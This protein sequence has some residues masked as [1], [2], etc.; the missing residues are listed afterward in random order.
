[1]RAIIRLRLVDHPWLICVFSR[2]RPVE[3]SLTFVDGQSIHEAFSQIS[4]ASLRSICLRHFPIVRAKARSELYVLVAQAP[5]SIQ[6]LIRQLTLEALQESGQRYSSRTKARPSDCGPGLG[7]TPFS[8]TP[9][10]SLDGREPHE[11]FMRAPS[12]ETI[13]GAIEEFIDRT[14]N[15][16]LA[17]GVCAVC[18]CETN[19]R[20][21]SVQRLN[22][23]PNGHRLRPT[24]AHPH[25]TLFDE[26]LL[27]LSGITSDT[28]ANVC[29]ECTRALALDKIPTFALA[30]GMWIGDIPHEL[31]YL[32]LPERLLI[33]K[34]FPAAYIIKLYPKKKGA[35]HW[36]KRQMYSG[37]KGNVSTYQLDQNQISSM[38]DGS[39]MP[40]RTEV[41]AATIGITFVGPKNL[42]DRGLPDLFK[43]RRLRVQRALEWLKANNPLFANITISASRLA[44]LP[45]DG[46]PYELQATTKFSSDT[47]TL[48]AEQDGYVPSQDANEDVE[49]GEH[50][51]SSQFSFDVPWD[52][53][54]TVSD[55]SESEGDCI[56]YF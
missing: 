32:T 9:H 45:E 27:H 25:H 10:S 50:S 4:A 33:A 16:A 56:F 23:I 18:A 3:D 17:V 14:N 43:V 38:V 13:D 34:Y 54:S 24:E 52:S 42:P 15:L 2:K 28:S 5:D 30:N 53:T 8:E 12:K 31:A 49:A 6:Q 29:A 44:A 48:Y 41:L 40:Q 21:L 26:M 47:S 22:C 46:M 55:S 20:E 19:K 11:S 7:G 35:R 51:H 1:V 39:I 37:L 36:D